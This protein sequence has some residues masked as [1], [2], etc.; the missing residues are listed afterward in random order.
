VSDEIEQAP[1][2]AVARAEPSEED[3][4]TDGVPAGGEK[5]PADP[6]PPFARQVSNRVFP[7]G[8]RPGSDG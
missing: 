7:A 2:E 4:R 5:P 3:A 1:A 8:R 6:R